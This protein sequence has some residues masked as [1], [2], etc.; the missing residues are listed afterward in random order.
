VPVDVHGPSDVG[1]T[2]ARGMKFLSVTA[3]EGQFDAVTYQ[4]QAQRCRN[5][6]HLDLFKTADCAQGSGGCFP[7][8]LTDGLRGTWVTEFWEGLRLM[9]VMGF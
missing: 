6:R 4:H 7:R 1:F 9:M 2:V 8:L 3:E 5:E